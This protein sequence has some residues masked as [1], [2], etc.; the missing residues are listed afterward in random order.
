MVKTLSAP[1]SGAVWDGF[2]EAGAIEGERTLELRD[3]TVRMLEVRAIANVAPGVH[4]AAMRD[5]SE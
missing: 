4:L 1:G 2:L 3:G 5:V